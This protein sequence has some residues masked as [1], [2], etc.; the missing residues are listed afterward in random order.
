MSLKL[1]V[2]FQAPGAA[3]RR[4][5]GLTHV[6]TGV[7]RRSFLTAL[8]I[9]AYTLPAPAGEPAPINYTIP[10][11]R[12]IQVVIDRLLG[13]LEGVTH[14]Q[15]VERNTGAIV[16]DFSQP[17]DVVFAA[18]PGGRTVWIY[19]FGVINAALI[20]ATEILGDDRYV[21]YVKRNHAFAFGQLEYLRQCNERFGPR[22]ER[23]RGFIAPE[24]LDDCGALGMALIRLQPHLRTAEPRQRA[25][26][27]LIAD[28]VSRRQFRLA[29]GTLARTFTQPETLW[30]D[31]LYMSVPFWAEMGRLT[32]DRQYWDDAVR[33][34]R[35]FAARLF[36][37]QNGLFDHAWFSNQP[38]N[39]RF[40]WGRAAG[41][42]IVAMAELLSV[43]PED[44]PGR[45]EILRLFQRNAR[46]LLECQDGTG[47]WHQL[48][49]RENTYLETSCS[50]MFAF[51]L[52]RGVNRGW[53]PPSYATA[54]Q[55]AWR[56]IEGRITPEGR[57]DG[58]CPGTGVGLEAVFY[59][60]R[61]PY[62]HAF[63]GY[64]PIIMAGVELIE[65][66]KHFTIERTEAT[67]Y[68]RTPTANA[69]KSDT[70]ARR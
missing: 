36:D 24:S 23:L 21:D 6:I 20:H 65:L 15:L 28:Y 45:G 1:H 64:G 12:E 41:W 27:E 8:L 18:L 11:P 56:A 34:V 4:I 14:R 60:N 42:A 53:L 31:D 16:T 44:H 32:G 35:Q 51:A 48:L 62:A 59:A 26:I 55:V 49:D 38:D 37:E 43:L 52:A 33:Q 29:D 69:S 3:N 5:G 2:S 66:Q 25:V 47:L 50:A 10:T 7:C 13:Y 70:P 46:G 17:R 68:Y 22:R 67:F 40:F 58:V 39:P 9:A 30:A 19:E 54:A 61:A 63:H 57:T